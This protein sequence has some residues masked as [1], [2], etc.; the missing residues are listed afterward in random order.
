VLAP[1]V[2]PPVVVPLDDVEE[3]VVELLVPVLEP[4]DPPDVLVDEEVLA[5]DPVPLVEE[6]EV[7]V[8]LPLL[9][10]LL[11]PV[12]TSTRNPMTPEVAS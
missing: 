2:V 4:L 11:H 1:L 12:A 3:L 8:E 10:L 7:P 9:G 5:D 6:F